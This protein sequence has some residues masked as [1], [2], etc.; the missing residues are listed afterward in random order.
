MLSNTIFFYIFKQVVHKYTVLF[1]NRVHSS[2]ICKVITVFT[3]KGKQ[4]S[5]DKL[6]ENKR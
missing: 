2:L 4:T 5:N 6:S 3:F 1:L